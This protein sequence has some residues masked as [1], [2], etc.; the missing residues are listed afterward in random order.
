[1]YLY[2]TAEQNTAMAAAASAANGEKRA[3]YLS[4][5]GASIGSNAAVKLYRNATAVWVAALSGALPVVGPAIVIT[6]ATQS[7]V[8]VADID[9]GTWELRVEKS[10]DSAIYIGATVT[11]ATVAESF[12]LSADLAADST[13]SINITF[14]AP[15]LDTVGGGGDSGG[16][17]ITL[18]LLQS[19]VNTSLQH[20]MFMD[21]VPPEW[22]WGSHARAGVGANPPQAVGWNNPAWV[23][24][25]QAATERNN[26]PGTHNWRFASLEI[27]THERRAGVWQ[28]IHAAV[29]THDKQYGSMY[30]DYETNASTS[31]NV[32]TSNGYDEIA[33]P[34]AGG[35]YHYFPSF[36]IN[37]Q[38]TGAQHR[39]VLLRCALTL[40]DPQGVDDRAAA[41]VVALAGGDYWKTNP[42]VW[43][44]ANYSNDDFWIGRA[45]KPALW[46]ATSWHSAHTMTSEADINEYIAWLATQGIG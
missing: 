34:N 1:M 15:A 26:A 12:R 10:T 4:S 20:E 24:W 40:D 25:G 39:V 31:A 32:R 45:R 13:V 18:E 41:R 37:I 7:S 22:S 23:A 28:A 5:W 27:H 30:L 33:F 11:A 46:P 35:A 8:S 16:S 2:S 21:G 3:A 6:A 44:P 14:N 38:P 36:T 19:D 29:L 17:W 9:T 43:D 42:P